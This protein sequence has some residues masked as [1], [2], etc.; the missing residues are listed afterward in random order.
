MVKKLT[1]SFIF[2]GSL[3]AMLLVFGFGQDTRLSAVTGE[4]TTTCENKWPEIIDPANGETIANTFPVQINTPSTY[5]PSNVKL[6]VDGTVVGQATTT[7]STSWKFHWDS[8]A[9]KNGTHKLKARAIYNDGSTIYSCDSS[10]IE[11]NV[12]NDSN[13]IQTYTL[14]A[15]IEPNEWSGTTNVSRT[16]EAKAK[17]VSSSGDSKDVTTNASYTWGTTLGTVKG[18]GRKADFFSGSTAGTG[19]IKVLVQYNGYK[20]SYA[21]SIEI[22]KQ[23]TSTYPSSDTETT[24]STENTTKTDEKETETS[25]TEPVA[26]SND[27]GDPELEQCLK[28]VLGDNRYAKIISGD[29]RLTFTELAELKDCFEDRKNIIPANLA[30]IEPEKITQLPERSDKISVTGVRNEKADSKDL[31]ILQGQ[32]APDST[33]LIYVFSEPL[34]LTAQSSSSGQWTY[35]LED[36]LEPGEHEVYVAVEDSEDVAVR[37]APFFMNIAQAESTEDNPS[38]ASLVLVNA[39]NDTNGSREFIYIGAGI[40]VAAL[41]S[42]LTFI[43][44]KNLKTP[45][46]ASGSSDQSVSAFMGSASVKQPDIAAAPQPGNTATPSTQDTTSGQDMNGPDHG[47]GK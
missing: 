18:Y 21:A 40:V 15:E 37:S 8:T 43:H 39:A 17:L 19:K 1:L 10:S 11:V 31:L 9:H 2:L 45:L 6:L 46:S 27:S 47:T 29:Q 26:D 12:N 14:H 28:Q 20:D 32:A 24:D 36:P 3:V 35:T 34:V 44:M 33:V 13:T 4:T 41:V 23:D 38:G 22:T 16:F 5:Q 7:D 30:P 42:I 25:N